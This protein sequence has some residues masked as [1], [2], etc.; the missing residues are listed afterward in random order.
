M[1]ACQQF[2]HILSL[3]SY[4]NVSLLQKNAPTPPGPE[5]D[6][7]S[8]FDNRPRGEDDGEVITT[9]SIHAS[10]SSEAFISASANDR[11]CHPRD[12][13]NHVS[14]STPDS[15]PPP[16][17]TDFRPRPTSVEVNH[18][19]MDT[20]GGHGRDPRAVGMQQQQQAHPQQPQAVTHSPGNITPPNNIPRCGSASERTTLWSFE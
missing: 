10:A 8:P 1:A 18:T 2:P 12:A 4:S 16:L 7:Q 17:Y 13:L 5:D 14:I 3:Y 19:P 6:Y 15:R 11:Y 9:K 20:T